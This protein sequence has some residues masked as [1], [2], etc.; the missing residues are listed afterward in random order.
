MQSRISSRQAGLSSIDAPNGAQAGPVSSMTREKLPDSGRGGI[1]VWARPSG[2]RK[3]PGQ[4]E[5]PR[6]NRD[7]HVLAGV[8]L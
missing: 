8:L 1:A 2:I 4:V 6:C 3:L 7:E 5:D